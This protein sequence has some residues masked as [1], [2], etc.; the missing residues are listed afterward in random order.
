MLDKETILSEIRRLAERSGGRPPGGATFTKATGIGQHEWKGVFWRR[1][2]KA[3][4]E[5]GFMP[6]KFGGR[7]AY[8]RAR[9]TPCVNLQRVG[10]P[11][12]AGLPG[13]V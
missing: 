8:H 4:A 1:W 13:G 12:V 6:N 7:R 3:Q 10:E 5:V 2:S 9:E 11:E